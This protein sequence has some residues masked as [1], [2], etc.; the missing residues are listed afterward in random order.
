MNHSNIVLIVLLAGLLLTVFPVQA[1]T[2]S[3][4]Y[5]EQSKPLQFIEEEVLWG[6]ASALATWASLNL[7]RVPCSHTCALGGPDCSFVCFIAFMFAS[8]WVTP[9]GASI[10]VTWSVFQH[11]ISWNMG[12]ITSAYVVSL[13][14]ETL[15]LR[16]L[17]TFPAP[18]PR[19]FL[20]V[21]SL[22]IAEGL[23]ATAGFNLWSMVE[24]SPEH[25]NTYSKAEKALLSVQLA[26]F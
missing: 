16:L 26:S 12:H 13:M 18:P 1:M 3:Q 6:S 17:R 4:Q 25:G 8:Y 20:G 21:L 22:C 24:T 11:G 14:T 19:Q 7:L 5:E 9:L 10:G 2:Q 23:G 15:I